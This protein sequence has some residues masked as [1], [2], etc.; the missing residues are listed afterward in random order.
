MVDRI[1]CRGMV[2]Q[3]SPMGENDKRIVL[4][5]KELGRISCFVRGARRPGNHLMAASDSFAFGEFDLI[6]GR[7]AYTLTE[8]RISDFFRELT[9]DVLISYS[10]YYFLELAKYFSAEGMDGGEI[11]NLIYASFKALGA[12][13]MPPK[14]IRLVFEEKLLVIN[15][16]YPD[17]SRCS[18]C[19]KNEDITGFSIDRNSVVCTCCKGKNPELDIVPVSETTLYTLRFVLSHT[20]KGLF[21]FTVRSDVLSEYEAVMERCMSKYVGRKMNSAEIL[22]QLY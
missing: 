3:S 11:L 1:T 15:G 13:K 9:T 8:A 5:T 4:L 16:E 20:I 14:L 12:G 17:F 21:S 7:D 10:A 22:S 19:M 2:I 6:A 18:F